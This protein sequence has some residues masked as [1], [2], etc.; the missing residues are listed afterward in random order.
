MD[1]NNLYNEE[2]NDDI[3][4]NKKPGFGSKPGII[5]IVFPAATAICYIN[6]IKK[7]NDVFLMIVTI[8]L[9]LIGIVLCFLFVKKKL[10]NEKVGL[11]GIIISAGVLFHM[12]IYIG[13]AV[14]LVYLL[15]Y[16]LE[17]FFAGW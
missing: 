4:E 12:I 13:P 14:A 16:L 10:I 15:A 9:S 1:N 8:I 17:F 7:W 5:A 11:A 3:G 6:L 2:K